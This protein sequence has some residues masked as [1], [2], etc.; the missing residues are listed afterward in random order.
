[1]PLPR[2]LRRMLAVS[3]SIVV[4]SLVSKVEA[5]QN[6]PPVDV[7]PG[8]RSEPARTVRAPAAPSTRVPSAPAS[9]A[10]PPAVTAGSGPIIGA[11]RNAMTTVYS[12][13]PKGIALMT[14]N[15]GANPLRAI[16]G[17]PSVDAPAIDPYGLAN[18]PGSYKGLRIRGEVSQHGNSTSLFEGLPLSGIDPGPGATFMIDNEN[19]SGVTLYQG[20]PPS[21]LNSYFTLPGVVDSR[22]RWGASKMGGEISQSVGSASFL[23]TFGRVDS[24]DILNGTTRVFVSGSW[25]DAHQWRGPGQAPQGK[26]GFSLGVDTKPSDAI[27]AKVFVAR[28]SYNANT[29][30]GLNYLQAS[31]LAAN[32]WYNFLPVSSGS[33]AFAVNYFNYNL[34]NFD[35]WTAFSEV[36][37]KFDNATKLVV[38]PYYFREDG[39]YLDGMANGMVRKWQINHDSWGVVSEID[40]RLLETSIKIGH[41]YGQQNLPG[42]P[43]GWQMFT[44]NALGGATNPQWAILAQQTSP[45]VNNAVYGQARRDFGPLHVQ[46]GVRYMWERMAGIA[47]HTSFGSPV[48]M[49][50]A[51]AL[52]LSSGVIPSRSVNGF[53]VGTFLPSGAVTYDVSNDLQLKVSGGVG[54]GGPGFDVWPAY[55]QNVAAFQKYGITADSLWRSI[56]PETSEMVDA[57]LRYAFAGG[58]GSGYVEPIFYYA[59]NHHKSVAY[60]PGIGVAYSQNVGESESYGGQAIGHWSPVQNLD[61]FAS[62][63]YQHAAFVSDLPVLPGASMTTVL[64]THVA[65]HQ[66]PD[67]PYWLSTVG[68][69][70]RIE[71]YSFSPILR[72]VGGR[73]GDTT[74]L[75]PIPGYATLDL[76]FGY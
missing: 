19:L 50:L 2:S 31:N 58:Y 11:P 62:V 9:V 43:T 13:D 44:P 46:A 56:R 67:V 52:T 45:H 15:G 76:N 41:W 12:V 23:R 35:S 55:Q 36:A 64:L 39:Y 63:G 33:P 40:T 28:S 69:D 10:A 68:A 47:E 21:N 61:L 60:D 8:A 53:T 38:K 57:G 14:G 24:G 49:S 65:G 3:F 54:Y 34:Q 48:D 75:Q 74:G 37:V 72:I 1:M 16:G 27:E 29:Y 26:S 17:L 6:L 51:T 20:P 5:Q 18:L 7:A 4:A 73:A 42:P 30:A 25:T 66:L 59:R 70:L 32:R 22:L 71:N